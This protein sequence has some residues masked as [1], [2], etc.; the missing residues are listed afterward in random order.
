MS[1]NTYLYHNRNNWQEISIGIA[2]YIHLNKIT[3]NELYREW[4]S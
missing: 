1:G 4:D 2:V 3:D